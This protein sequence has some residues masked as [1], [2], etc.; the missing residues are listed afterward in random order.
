LR[1]AAINLTDVMTQCQFTPSLNRLISV[2]FFTRT[3]KMNVIPPLF[4]RT[5]TYRHNATTLF[6]S[7][8]TRDSRQSERPRHETSDTCLSVT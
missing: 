2:H 8:M 1:P 3:V 4:R 7:L 6:Y 5:L